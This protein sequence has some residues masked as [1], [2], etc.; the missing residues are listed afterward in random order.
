MQNCVLKFSSLS[1]D[2]AFSTS[3]SALDCTGNIYVKVVK[4]FYECKRVVFE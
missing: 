4:I 2:F 3:D 1:Q